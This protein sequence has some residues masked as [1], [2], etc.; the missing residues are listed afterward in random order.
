MYQHMDEY[1]DIVQLLN[2][3]RRDDGNETSQVIDYVADACM[4]SNHLWQDMQLPNRKALSEL[5]LHHFPTLAAKNTG[6]MKWKKFF[7]KQLCE[8]EDIFIC[9]SPSCSECVDYQQ[10][11]GS[12]EAT[13]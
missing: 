11:F 12:E 6:D 3:H 8:R 10:C 2:D 7:Y 1:D 5:M 4:G 13:S 9:K